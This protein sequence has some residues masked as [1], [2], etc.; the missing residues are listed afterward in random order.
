MD[1]TC[2]VVTL[3]YLQLL[4]VGCSPQQ[5]QKL[6]EALDKTVISKTKIGWEL[7]ELETAAKLV[8][9]TV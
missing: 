2:K 4:F 5:L 9:L 6:A 7:D 8:S 1:T 3:K